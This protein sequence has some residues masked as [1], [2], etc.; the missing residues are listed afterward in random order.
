MHTVTAICR[1]EGCCYSIYCVLFAANAVPSC[2]QFSSTHQRML[3][4]ATRS[5]LGVCLCLL[6]SSHLVDNGTTSSR[7][8]YRTVA[9]HNL[10]PVRQYSCC[11]V[12]NLNNATGR[13]PRS[14]VMLLQCGRMLKSGHGLIYSVLKNIYCDYGDILLFD[15]LHENFM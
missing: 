11:L 9:E 5:S 2:C 10:Q 7:Q 14:C 1:S 13:T 3:C 12:L 8:E 6:Q 15:N 4:Y